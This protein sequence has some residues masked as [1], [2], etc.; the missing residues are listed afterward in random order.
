MFVLEAEL[1][2]ASETTEAKARSQQEAQRALAALV[3]RLGGN[4]Y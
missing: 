2:K 4:S 1:R 3:A